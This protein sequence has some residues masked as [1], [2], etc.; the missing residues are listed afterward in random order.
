MATE[1]RDR[2]TVLV[3]SDDDE[4]GSLLALNLRR[5]QLTVEQTTFRVAASPRWSPACVHPGVVV[6]SAE[7][8]NTDPLAFLRA[9]RDQPWLL[10]VH[11]VLA[12]H[13]SARIITKL[14]NPITMI[15]TE[16]DDVGAIV[17]AI[18]AHVPSDLPVVAIDCNAYN[19]GMTPRLGATNSTSTRR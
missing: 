12:A 8:S 6:L 10:D 19:E 14:G 18:Q 1:D 17:A 2:A 13:D 5:R 11:L 15:A 4:L 16:P 7:R 9:T 3:I